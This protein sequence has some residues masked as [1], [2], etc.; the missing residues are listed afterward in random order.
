MDTLFVELRLFNGESDGDSFFE[1]FHELEEECTKNS[2]ENPMTREA[3]LEFVDIFFAGM[4]FHFAGGRAV[5]CEV[6]VND[7]G[8]RIV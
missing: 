7:S 1:R 2:V 5:G 6:W 8:H 3:R 4:E